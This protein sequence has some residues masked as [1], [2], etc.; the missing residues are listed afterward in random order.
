MRRK[1]TEAMTERRAAARSLVLS[2]SLARRV[3]QLQRLAAAPRC[4]ASAAGGTIDISAL[5]L[6]IAELA[7]QHAG[8]RRYVAAVTACESAD[9]LTQDSRAIPAEARAVALTKAEEERRM[10]EGESRRRR[11]ARMAALSKRGNAKRQKTAAEEAQEYIA[12]A[13]RL[14]KAPHTSQWRLSAIIRYIRA[15]D[16]DCPFGPRQ[17]RRHLSAAGLK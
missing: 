4:L 13:T 17:L 2:G 3:A 6:A 8:A 7:L 9:R 1:A 5:I 11:A 16:R 15:N 14:R 10:H 12:E